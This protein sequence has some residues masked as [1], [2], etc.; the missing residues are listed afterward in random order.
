[1]NRFGLTICAVLA[2]WGPILASAEDNPTLDPNPPQNKPVLLLQG[3][4]A[5]FRGMLSPLDMLA[6]ITA[7]AEG[8]DR[9]IETARE[10]E[11]DLAEIDLQLEE[12]LREVDQERY[13][14]ELE[15]LRATVERVEPDWWEHP[16][17]WFGLGIVAA[18]AVTAGSV[19]I[20]EATR[21]IAVES[22]W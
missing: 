13:E 4:P 21:P 19:S 14:A 8:C 11:R 18:I 2:S 1:M 17:I 7:R 20:I 16:A 3:D 9:R 15:L 22:I 5:P 12:H 10:W 6:T